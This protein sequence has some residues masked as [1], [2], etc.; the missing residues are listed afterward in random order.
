[1]GEPLYLSLYQINTRILLT[2]FYR[3]RNL[4]PRGKRTRFA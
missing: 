2:E 4:R 3:D 1:M